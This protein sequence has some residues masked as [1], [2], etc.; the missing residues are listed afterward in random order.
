MHTPPEH[1]LPAAHSPSVA[2]LPAQPVAPH[3][4]GAQGCCCSGGQPPW[5]SQPAASTAVPLAQLPARH[6]TAEPG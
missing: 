6:A 4:N 3:E 2:Q 5:P 1:Q